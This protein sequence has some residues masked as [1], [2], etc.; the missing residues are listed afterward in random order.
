MPLARLYVGGLSV[1]KQELHLQI[2]W[3]V[4]LGS[5]SKMCTTTIGTL[6]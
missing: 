5:H 3:Q 4:V 6:L 2:P 1:E